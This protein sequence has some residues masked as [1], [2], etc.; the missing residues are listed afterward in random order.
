[1][2]EATTPGRVANMRLHLPVKQLRR[3]DPLNG[4]RRAHVPPTDLEVFKGM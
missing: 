2:T 4:Y 1:M 3:A